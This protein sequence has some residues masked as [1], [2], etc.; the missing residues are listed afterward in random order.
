MEKY[1][2]DLTELLLE[3]IV[4]EERLLSSGRVS[5]YYLDFGRINTARN[6]LQFDELFFLRFKDI[7]AS[8]NLLFNVLYGASGTG[9]LLARALVSK[10]SDIRPNLDFSYGREKEIKKGSRIGYLDGYHP[11]AL[12]NVL[13]IDSAISTGNKLNRE[14]TKILDTG[15]S[16]SGFVVVFDRKERSGVRYASEELADKFGVGVYSCVNVDDFSSLLPDGDVVKRMIAEQQEE[17]GIKHYNF[18]SL[19]QSGLDYATRIIVKDL[20]VVGDLEAQMV[21]D[22]VS[23]RTGVSKKHIFSDSRYKN[24]VRARQLTMYLLRQSGVSFPAIGRM[25]GRDHS[26][27]IHGCRTISD[28]LPE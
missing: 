25:L 21:I 7:V 23:Y 19:D 11:K 4:P 14:A 10:F 15:A 18:F 9:S 13:I 24:I 17:F 26:T 28:I 16:L 8:N 2:K 27:V 20:L 22:L 1:E 12:D 3:R 6:I 5:R